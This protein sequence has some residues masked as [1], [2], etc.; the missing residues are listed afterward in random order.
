MKKHLNTLF[1]TLDGAYL[2]KDGEA[3]EVRF[4]G[5]T[6]LRV[7]LHNLDG[8]VTFGW[9]TVASVSL[10]GACTERGVALSFLTPNGHF[11]A[12]ATGFPSGN[13][14]LRRQQYRLADDETASAAIARHIVSAKIANCRAVLLR[15]TRDRP[16]HPQRSA[17]EVAAADL[18]ARLSSLTRSTDLDIIR[19]VEGEAANTYFHVFQHL[20]GAGDEAMRFNGRTRRPPLDPIN[21]LLSF[22]Y[23][24]LAHDCRSACAACGLDPAVGFLHRDRPGRP[25][26]ALDLMEEFR[27][28]LADRLCL[29]LINRGQ[30]TSADFL[31]H[32]NGAVTLQ[33]DSRKKV[34]AAYQERKRDELRHP[35]L[36]E[37][38]TIGLLPHIQARL[39]ARHIRGDHDAYPAF[40]WR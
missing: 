35:F 28:M 23:A 12:A 22:L 16:D 32:E 10:M 30:I 34:L 6:K 3:V 27:P 5:E 21:A 39:L 24:I 38:M 18:S 29:T 15:A 31:F 19:G 8:I 36:E 17:L 9:D 14:L 13:V 7:P 20:I 4:E 1:V 40:L 2:R 37:T 25:G 11:Q 33:G 26:L